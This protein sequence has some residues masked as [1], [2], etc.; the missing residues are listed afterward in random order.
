M[1]FH[2]MHAKCRMKR[3]TTGPVQC[4]MS[5]IFEWWVKKMFFV[6]YKHQCI[7]RSA[8]GV[9]A[10][11][12]SKAKTVKSAC[13]WLIFIIQHPISTPAGS[14]ESNIHQWQVFSLELLFTQ[15][16]LMCSRFLEP[17]LSDRK[18]QCHQYKVTHANSTNC[19]FLFLMQISFL[20]WKP[21]FLNPSSRSS[22]WLRVM[23]A[24]A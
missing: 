2:E 18:F 24:G 21:Y 10:P 20:Y 4:F 17:Q 16:V 15:R 23:E 22:K 12:G 3:N 1:V 19:P 8:K 7:Q 13:F 14:M 11:H 5:V 9:R 6:I